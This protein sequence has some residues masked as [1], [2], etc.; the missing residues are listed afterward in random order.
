MNPISKQTRTEPTVIYAFASTS[1]R[2][3]LVA[4]KACAVS[5]VLMRSKIPQN[6]RDNIKIGLA[7]MKYDRA[8]RIQISQITDLHIQQFLIPLIFTI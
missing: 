5:W 6:F 3:I 2:S 1:L 8:D 4:L 7:E